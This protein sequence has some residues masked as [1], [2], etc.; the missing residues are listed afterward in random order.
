MLKFYRWVCLSSMVLASLS[1]YGSGSIKWT[2]D[3]RLP[4]GRIVTLTRY[5]EFKGP[6][7]LFQS[8]TESGYWFEFTNPDT[9]RV[10][11]RDGDRTQ[12][13]AELLLSDKAPWL[14]VRLTFN[15]WEK[16]DCPNPAFL[17]YKHEGDTWHQK[18][19][20]EIPVKRFRANM[21]G[22]VRVA[23]ETILKYHHH[24]P[25]EVTANSVIDNQEWQI[26]FEGLAKQTFG[27]ENC[28]HGNG[29]ISSQFGVPLR[30]QERSEK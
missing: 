23:E 10:V 1:A 4:D 25:V 2:E 28:V 22:S 13:T 6:H 9:G 17:L 21:T 30:P 26:S 12:Q 19:L 14:L 8:A 16:F 29:S 7:E 5:Q 18:P 15:G 11:R 20:E 24:L 3:V 27:T